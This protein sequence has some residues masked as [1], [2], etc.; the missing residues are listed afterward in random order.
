M[1]VSREALKELKKAA[2]IYE[3]LAGAQ[4][5]LEKAVEVEAALESRQRLSAT[6]AEKIEASE[7][8]L[9]DMRESIDREGAALLRLRTDSA[10]ERK[11]IEAATSKLQ[12]DH[13]ARTK[14]GEERAQK[15]E[16]AAAKATKKLAGLERRIAEQ[17]V[18]LDRLLARA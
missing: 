12:A 8:T 3:A 10:A 13:E 17:K 16:A 6:L 4:S 18:T 7:K 9:A 1:K 14:S 5:V 11:E 2:E 15:A